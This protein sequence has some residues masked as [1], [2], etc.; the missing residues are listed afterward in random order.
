MSVV[1]PTY[2]RP[3][4]VAEAFDSLLSQEVSPDEVLVVDDSTDDRV[5]EL[6]RVRSQR[7]LG[8]GIS[9]RHMRNP[10]ERG[11][12]AARN[13]GLEHTASEIVLFM[14]DDVVLE[15]GY[16]GA[17]LAVYDAHP[18]A[19]GVQGHMYRYGDGYDVHGVYNALRKAFS[20]T[21]ATERGCE[22]LR[23]FKATY[24]V[25]VEGVEPC[26]WLSGTNQTYRRS[27][28]GGLRFDERLKR[29]SLGEDMDLSFNVARQSGG[30]LYIAQGA[31][32]VHKEARA[33]RTRGDRLLYV[34]AVHSYYLFR[35]NMPQTFANRAVFCWS[36]LGRLLL[37]LSDWVK[38]FLGAPAPEV[39][40]RH[41]LGSQILW[42]S[43]RSRIASG[44]LGFMDAHL[45]AENL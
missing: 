41:I 4:H 33:E 44:D 21:Y 26:G 31:R 22:V 35:K 8:E 10:R 38:R 45:K 40:M 36:R 11:A 42:L 30:R 39:A 27:A 43:N 1:M 32:L 23:S 3:E 24:P 13:V 9:L 29:Y 7:F 6:V 15:P 19:A 20:L 5:A 25:R 14:D 2:N 16:L 17:V 12:S 37:N 28:L 18:D 34:D